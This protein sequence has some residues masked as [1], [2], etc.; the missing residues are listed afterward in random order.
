MRPA[1]SAPSPSGRCES[2]TTTAGCSRADNRTASA[3]VPAVPTT[4]MSP[5]AL[6][7]AASPSATRRW[8]STSSTLIGRCSGGKEHTILVVGDPELHDAAV[9]LGRRD[10]NPPPCHLGTLAHRDEAEVTGG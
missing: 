7:M 5:V 3:E 6:G 2:I 1:M 9:A 4:R 10:A 8:S